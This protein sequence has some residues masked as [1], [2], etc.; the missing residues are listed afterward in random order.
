MALLLGHALL[1]NRFHHRVTFV[2]VLQ[3]REHMATMQAHRRDP[4][5]APPIKN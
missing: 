5:L 2:H 1:A 4:T 3:Q